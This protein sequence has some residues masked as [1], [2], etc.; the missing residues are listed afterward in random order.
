M[1]NYQTISVELHNKVLNINLNRP[2]KHNAF[3]SQMI[4]ELTQAFAE[5]ANTSKARIILLQGNGKSF[6]AGADLHYMHEIAAFGFEENVNDGLKLAGLFDT[7]FHCPLPVVTFVK[8]VC[9][10]G[11]NGLVA[12]SDIVIADPDCSFAFSEVKL[13][14][15]PATIA[16]YVIR[17]CGQ[18]ASRELMLSGRKFS[19]SEAFRF[20]LVNAIAAPQDF[21]TIAAQYQNQLLTAAPQALSACKKLIEDIADSSMSTTELMPETARRI[22]MARASEEGREGIKA[23]FEKRK[24]FWAQDQQHENQ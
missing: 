20:G 24:P 23:F 14:I 1:I 2:E 12:A 7:V 11:A 4:R 15:I 21:E 10:G 22:A 16:P 5:A 9:M 8:G 19:A 18:G 3:N 6:C 17:R 13:G